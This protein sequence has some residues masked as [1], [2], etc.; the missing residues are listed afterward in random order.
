ML[1]RELFYM[2]TL[3][4][5]LLKEIVF[6]VYI[7]SDGEKKII[8]ITSV[9]AGITPY[10]IKRLY[11]KD[12]KITKLKKIYIWNLRKFVDQQSE[13]MIDIYRPF[14]RFLDGGLLVPSL[15]DQVLDIEKKSVNEAIKLGSRELKKTN[16]FGCEIISND[17][18]ALKFFYEKLHVPYIKK[19]HGTYAYI[20]NFDTIKK[21]YKKG[22]IVFATLNGERVAAYL[23][24]INGDI[25]CC[26]RNGALD[27]SFVKKGAL[28]ATYYFAILRAKKIDSK[29]VSFG[30]SRPFLSDGILRHKNQW[31]T[32]IYDDKTNKRFIYLKNVFFENP[33]IHIEDKKLIAVVFSENDKLMKEFG[34][35]GL[36]FNIVKNRNY[37]GS[38]I[39]IK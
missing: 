7:L 1:I 36:E 35:S 32:K 34:A 13:V 8:Y 33:F 15:V 38:E 14:V 2:A 18:D 25:Y 27:E 5:K 4:F 17:S 31:G 11:E 26:N 24:E 16:Q 6:D 20:E 9:S 21:I 29:K 3:P 39:E 30:K 19:R 23:C 10:Y 37:E 12:A 28:V 22:E